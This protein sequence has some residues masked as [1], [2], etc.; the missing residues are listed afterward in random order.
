MKRIIIKVLN[1]FLLITLILSI[2]F[3]FANFSVNIDRRVIFTKRNLDLLRKN[4]E[5]F[6]DIT[7]RNP[8]S[9]LEIVQYAKNNP[10]NKLFKKK[11][12]EFISDKNGNLCEYGVLNN[13]GGW[14]YNKITG[15]VKVNLINPIKYYLYFYFNDNRE[16]IPSNW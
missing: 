15:E 2:L 9:L 3:V 7:G 5:I 8:N 4:I 14:Y 10:K 13:K 11:F 16:D 6:K 1:Y 12:K